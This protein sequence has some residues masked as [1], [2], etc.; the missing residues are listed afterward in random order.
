MKYHISVGENKYD[1]EIG[2]IRDGVAMVTVNMS[3]YE[4]KIENFGEVASGTT[5]APAPQPAASAAPAASE[6]PVT[7]IFSQLPEA[8]PAAV[9]AGGVCMVV[10]PI[11][12]LVVEVKVNPGSRVLAGQ[13]VAVIEAMKMLNSITSQMSGTVREVRVK[14]GTEVS[15]DDVLMVIG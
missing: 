4:V 2:A 1:I 8:P 9:P 14:P 3:P 12:G 10:A 13:A 11:P 5:C 7:Q 15:T 6:P